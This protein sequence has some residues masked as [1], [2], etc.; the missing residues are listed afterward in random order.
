L[1]SNV[2]LLDISFTDLSSN[3]GLLDTSVNLLDASMAIVEKVASLRYRATDNTSYTGTTYKVITSFNISDISDG[4]SIIAT[5]EIFIPHTGIYSY[6]LQLG[7]T[8]SSTVSS[9]DLAINDNSANTIIANAG[10][11]GGVNRTYDISGSNTIGLS[12]ISNFTFGNIVQP[13]IKVTG[14][15]SV[16][17]DN[18]NQSIFS[19]A[20]LYATD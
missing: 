4:M 14:A 16:T 9:I 5:G 15:G 19:M 17:L 18:S 8:T 10:S 12:G 1:S 2:G 20:L 3:V 7:C 11:T 13:Y 6:N